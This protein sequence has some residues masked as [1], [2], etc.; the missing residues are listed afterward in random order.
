MTARALMAV[1]VASVVAVAASFA[2]PAKASDCG[3]AVLKAWDEGRLDS[4]FA[5]ACY[6]QALQEL[7][8]RRG[9]ELAVELGL[10]EEHDLH[11]LALLGLQV[12]EQAHGF[13]RFLRHR[14]RF[15][16]AQHHALLRARTIEQRA[17]QRAHDLVLLGRGLDYGNG[18]LAHHLP[19]I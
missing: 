3:K 19:T 15:I 16:H 10:A 4:S 7:P 9:L 8:E 12:G 5:P 6:R 2:A 1:L 18:V 14:L 11:E 13:E 17:R